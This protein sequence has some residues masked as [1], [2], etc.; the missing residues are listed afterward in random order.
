MSEDRVNEIENEA[1]ADE[2]D[3]IEFDDVDRAVA[4][5][6][7]GQRYAL[8]IG[9]VQEIQ[10]IV[11]FSE[12]PGGSSG[13]I[14]MINLRGAVIPAI[15]LRRLVGLMPAEYTLETPMIICH[16]QG[17]LLALVVDEVLDVIELPSEIMHEA[18]SMH[19]LAAK[20]LGVARLPDGLMYLLDVDALLAPVIGGGW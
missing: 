5:V 20:M 10:Q 2:M 17:K 12:V 13:V 19:S 7:D 8:P 16:V 3:A 6:L 15:D 11:A 1:E 14:G 9:R 18:P 4:F